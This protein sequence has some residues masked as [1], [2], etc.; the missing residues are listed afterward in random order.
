MVFIIFSLL[1]IGSKGKEE[2]V[3]VIGK[4]QCPRQV[5]MEIMLPFDESKI[6]DNG[7]KWGHM[8]V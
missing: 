5:Q 2:R 7:I 8:M 6:E 4:A 1:L 3:I